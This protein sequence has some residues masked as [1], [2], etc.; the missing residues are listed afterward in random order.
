[1]QIINITIVTLVNKKKNKNKKTN[2]HVIMAKSC[3]VNTVLL[4]NCI[5]LNYLLSFIAL[6][7]ITQAIH[8]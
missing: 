3:G 2:T 6:G 1:M 5:L 8:N 7:I 4:L